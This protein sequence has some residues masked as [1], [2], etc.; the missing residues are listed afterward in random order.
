MDDT[1]TSR[2]NTAAMTHWVVQQLKV[3]NPVILQL[4]S[5]P[6]SVALFLLTLMELSQLLRALATPEVA[7]AS[8]L[9]TAL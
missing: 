1:A 5:S 2:Y 9:K 6:F 8:N 3:L 7:N 4:D